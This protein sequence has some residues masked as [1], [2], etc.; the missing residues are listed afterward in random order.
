MVTSTASE[1]RILPP[2][3]RCAPR[4]CGDFDCSGD[5]I[6]R[7]WAHQLLGSRQAVAREGRK[8][9]GRR[10]T[11]RTRAPLFM[12]LQRQG[13]AEKYPPPS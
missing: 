4:I 1:L 9:S 6:Q 8:G 10:S 3:T 11:I 12:G 5:D 7:D 2:H 13:E